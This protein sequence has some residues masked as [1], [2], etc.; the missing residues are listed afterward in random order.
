MFLTEYE[1]F[2]NKLCIHLMTIETHLVCFYYMK[3]RRWWYTHIHTQTN[4]YIQSLDMLIKMHTVGL[5]RAHFGDQ[6]NSLLYA[7]TQIRTRVEMFVK[8]ICGSI[9]FYGFEK[10]VFLSMNRF[11]C[12]FS[13]L[14]V[15]CRIYS[16]AV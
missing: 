5:E 9:C 10:A 15:S 14:M 12:L 16:F 8:L 6:L 4:K 2:W 13:S 1:T 3:R 7:R 11:Q